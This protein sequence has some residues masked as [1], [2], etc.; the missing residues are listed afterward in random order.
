MTNPFN[1]SA[2]ESASSRLVLSA[3]FTSAGMKYLLAG[4]PSRSGDLSPLAQGTQDETT[5]MQVSSFSFTEDDSKS[6]REKP[7]MSTSSMQRDADDR[8]PHR[9]SPLEHLDHAASAPSASFDEAKEENA[10]I[11]SLPV[12]TEQ[13]KKQSSTTCSA[14]AT[15]STSTSNDRGKRRSAKLGRVLRNLETSLVGAEDLSQQRLLADDSSLTIRRK[16]RSR[17]PKNVSSTPIVS[18]DNKKVPA[19][20]KQ[21]DAHKRTPKQ[22]VSN[23]KP[24]PTSAAVVK[25]AQS[26]VTRSEFESYS[27]VTKTSFSSLQSIPTKRSTSRHAKIVA[28]A[29]IR[30]TAS[31]RTSSHSSKKMMSSTTN[32]MSSPLSM[33]GNAVEDSLVS[34][35]TTT[36]NALGSPA[37]D[38][39]AMLSPDKEE[40]DLTRKRKEERV[41][42]FSKKQKILN[43]HPGELTTDNR[44]S[45]LS[46]TLE[47]ELKPD[48]LIPSTRS[49]PDSTTQLMVSISEASKAS[50]KVKSSTVSLPQPRPDFRP[51]PEVN[52]PSPTK[53]ESNP[54]P[55]TNAP[56]A[57]ATERTVSVTPDPCTVAS[58]CSMTS[59]VSSTGTA[60]GSSQA[61]PNEDRYR[62]PP[63]SAEIFDADEMQTYFSNLLEF[64][65]GGEQVELPPLVVNTLAGADSNDGSEDSF[66]PLCV[67]SSHS[68]IEQPLATILLDESLLEE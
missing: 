65:D 37:L 29:S 36:P 58:I 28:M 20:K 22:I 8:A 66:K 34:C 9:A 19:G 16:L 63:S 21:H 17:S 7:P 44:G 25:T 54:V 68:I 2:E 64:G 42:T 41:T 47:Q 23:K 1:L 60:I 24:A 43:H 31:G 14:Y 3:V 11:E 52:E 55:T 33:G 49:P 48:A 67:F 35:M 18:R 38:A 5:S 56:S 4:A 6:S 62:H 15:K 57:T 45:T 12:E 13:T 32:A 30:N 50:P 53:T 10:L 51:I 39:S 27:P 26:Q 40:R 59:T 61:Q 46:A